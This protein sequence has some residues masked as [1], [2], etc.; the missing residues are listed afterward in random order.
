MAAESA[1]KRAFREYAISGGTDDYGAFVKNG[2][3]DDQKLY[4]DTRQ[5]LKYIEQFKREC[6]GAPA[7]KQ[8][9]KR[10]EVRVS[11]ED[12]EGFFFFT[13]KCVLVEQYH[14]GK[15]KQEDISAQKLGGEVP[16]F[17]FEDTE[18]AKQYKLYKD[19][20]DYLFRISEEPHNKEQLKLNNEQREKDR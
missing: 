20:F 7:G 8:Q 15:L 16:V 5:T 11:P 6:E 14:F 1:K 12:P 17:E 4:V 3:Y 10:I 18:T 19:H 2:A 9:N 13:E